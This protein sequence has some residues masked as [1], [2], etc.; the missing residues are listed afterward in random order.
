MDV[1][2]RMQLA[3]STNA[4]VLAL[5]L[6]KIFRKITPKWTKQGKADLPTWNEPHGDLIHH[7]GDAG[8]RKEDAGNQ[9]EVID[10]PQLHT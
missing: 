10:Q 9:V 8:Q 5:L 2:T 6:H 3:S 1:K 7:I 4:T